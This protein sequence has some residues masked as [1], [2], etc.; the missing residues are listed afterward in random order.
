MNNII[1]IFVIIFFTLFFFKKN[2]ELFDISNNNL[3][4][5][6]CATHDNDD[7][8]KL[9]NSLDRFNFN[10]HTICWGKEWK[11]SGY[12]MRMQDTLDYVKKLKDT[13]IVLYLDGYDI[14]NLG[15]INE[16]INKY[17]SFKSD[18]VFAAEKGL[19]PDISLG[20][21]NLIPNINKSYPYLNAQFIGKVST[22]KK[23]LEQA[24]KHLTADDQGEFWHYF[25]NHQNECTLDYKCSIFQCLHDVDID[26]DFLIDNKRLINKEFNTKPLFLHGNGTDG[27]YKL[28]K[29]YDLIEPY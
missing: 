2:T 25:L 20:Y 3:H 16:L 10:H 14:I 1:L 6:V 17:L 26:N 22:V 27:K 5:I 29:L 24:H 7:Y 21:H 9:I 28:N 13:D 23:M 12:G 11:G 15:N 19:W 4:V 18:I 8:K